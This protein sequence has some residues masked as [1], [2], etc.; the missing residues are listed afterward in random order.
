[1]TINAIKSLL[2]LVTISSLCFVS[3]K[4]TEIE[5]PVGNDVLLPYNKVSDLFD[6]QEPK[7]QKFTITPT[8]AQTITGED[9]TKIT[10]SANSFVDAQGNLVTGQID[11]ELQEIYSKGDMIWSERMTVASNGQ[12][13]E[14]GGEFFMSATSGGQEVFLNQ[15]YFMEV[16][17]SSATSNPS[18]MDLFTS[19]ESDST[20]TP[21]D[22]SWVGIDSL[23]SNYQFYFDSLT[24]INCDYFVGGANMTNAFSVEPRLSAGVNLTDVTAYVVFNN[25]NSVASL[26]YNPTT[27][28][29]GTSFQLPIGE[30]V[31]IVIVG[32]DASQIYLG[33]L[34][35]TISA[36]TS[37]IQV[38]MSPVTQ[39]QLQ[40]TI[41]NL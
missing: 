8:S 17:I 35:T 24:W 4:E 28:T 26:Y 16:P 41:N 21:V 30:S 34:N 36:V 23:N 20:W 6:N 22:S 15:D 25:L 13:L 14:S 29:F 32:M 11:F 33:T 7:K 3:C 39:T 38:P 18:A 9:G 5:Q 1:M 10:F 31:T 19:T 40:T 37:P 2:V 27:G 12:L